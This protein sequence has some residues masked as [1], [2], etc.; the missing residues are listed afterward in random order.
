M[1]PDFGG[2]FDQM[3]THFEDLALTY[4]LSGQVS[5]E[6]RNLQLTSETKAPIL[7]TSTTI[8][9]ISNPV[10][11][12]DPPKIVLKGCDCTRWVQ[13]YSR[14]LRG[15]NWHLCGS[16]VCSVTHLPDCIFCNPS[17][18]TRNTSISASLKSLI[19]GKA[20][21]ATV[22]ITSKSWRISISPS[23]TFRPI[24]SNDSPA[25][26]LFGIVNT[27]KARENLADYLKFTASSILQLYRD[28]KASPVDV[29]VRG[30]TVL[31]VGEP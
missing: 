24:V 10:S 7:S 30:E 26:A 4:P 19:L 16:H 22:S 11:S 2:R 5:Q 1:L 25:F 6:G 14:T 27:G 8:T 28:G 31:L 3:L 29:N 17:Q 13:R 21:E 12:L 9:D 18:W 15:R 20:I 23:L